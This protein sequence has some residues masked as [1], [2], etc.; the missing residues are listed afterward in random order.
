MRVA[1]L[2]IR[3]GAVR[4]FCVGDD[5]ASLLWVANLP[6]LSWTPTARMEAPEEPTA[7]VFDLDPGP[8]AGLLDAC[9]VGLR[10]RDAP[11]E[12]GLRTVVKT[13]GSRGL[14]DFAGLAP[15]GSF[16]ATQGFARDG[17][18]ARRRRPP[19]A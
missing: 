13:S 6:R 14:H 1:P 17:G 11:A 16:T 2:R 15:R 7:V 3:T 4:T 8:G 12:Q 18:A 5:T 9:R 19:Q 10:V